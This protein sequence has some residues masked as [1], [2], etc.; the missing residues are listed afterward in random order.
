[1]VVKE[2]DFAEALDFTR[3]NRTKLVWLGRE[4]VERIRE[5]LEL[6]SSKLIAAEPDSIVNASQDEAVKFKDYVF[7]CYHGNTSRYVANALKDKF[8]VDSLNLKGGITAVVGE[9]F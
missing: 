1:M 7:V 5:L 6:D 2:V 8:G 4:P 9:I 3:R